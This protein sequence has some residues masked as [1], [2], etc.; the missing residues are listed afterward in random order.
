M[1]HDDEP[2]IDRKGH[3]IAPGDRKHPS[4]RDRRRSGLGRNY[5]QGVGYGGYDVELDQAESQ[6]GTADHVRK[7]EDATK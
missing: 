5:G 4:G 6:T 7:G 3:E 2:E 1:R